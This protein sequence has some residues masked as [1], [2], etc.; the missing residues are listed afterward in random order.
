MALKSP[1]LRACPH[2]TQREARVLETRA[3]AELRSL[4]NL[5]ARLVREELRRKP[6][7]RRVTTA[8][9]GD[10]RIPYDVNIPLTPREQRAL[11]ARAAAEDRS[12]SSLV[13]ALILEELASG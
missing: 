3:A 13:A 12:L 5:L 1:R 8:K 4:A 11:K 7:G 6:P 10:Q 9:P 2:L